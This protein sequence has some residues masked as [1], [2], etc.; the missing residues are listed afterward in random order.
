MERVHELHRELALFHR[1][2]NLAA[3]LAHLPVDFRQREGDPYGA[4]AAVREY[5][6]V[7]E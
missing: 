4:S 6:H 2:A 7:E 5:R 3:D 1:P